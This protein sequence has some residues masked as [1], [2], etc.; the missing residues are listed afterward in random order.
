MKPLLD[1]VDRQIINHLQDGLDICDEPFAAPAA[2]IGIT[3]ED[4]V[5]RLQ[6]LRESGVLSRVGPM[7]NAAR[8]GGGLT[9]CAMAVPANDFERIAGIVNGFAAVAH[10]Y[11]RA[12]RY[13]M[14]FVLATESTERTGEVIAEIERLTD[15]KVLNLPKQEEYFIG[16]RVEA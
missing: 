12:H 11:E 10:N 4:L 9:L 13:N 16:L 6:R 2:E 7:F 5:A 14:W 15:V 3:V 8:M 1:H